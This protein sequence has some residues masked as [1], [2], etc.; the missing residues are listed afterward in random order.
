[1]LCVAALLF[2]IK[3]PSLEYEIHHR[4]RE[5]VKGCKEQRNGVFSRPVRLPGQTDLKN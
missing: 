2:Y 1:M 4:S 5:Y 3:R